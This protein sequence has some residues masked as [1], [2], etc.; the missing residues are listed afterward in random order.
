[1][2]DK[3]KNTLENIDALRDPENPTWNIDAQ[4]GK[5]INT[6]IR[7]NKPMRAA[8]IGTSTGYSGIWIAEALS[9][10]GGELFTVESHTERFE[11]AQKHFEESELTNITQIKGHAPEVLD[12]IP[13]NFDLLFFDATKCEHVS[14]FEALRH[15][16]NTGGIILADNMLS[17]ED[18]LEDYRAIVEAD[19]HFQSAL[20]P[21][22]TG[23]LMSVKI[24][25]N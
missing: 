10:H 21:I 25:N 20:I 22:G 7:A 18:V 4:T 3:I 8:E 16:L 17:H 6:L 13:G 19:P 9:H 1:M 14:Y 12:D 5:F 11:M 24:I 15:R 23:I 2:N